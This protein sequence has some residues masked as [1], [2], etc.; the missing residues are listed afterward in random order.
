MSLFA[1][2]DID[3]EPENLSPLSKLNINIF[4]V[5]GST[6]TISTSLA[7][8]HETI[9]VKSKTVIIPK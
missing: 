5:D 2:P 8:A 7:L 1:P 6:V 3:N 4:L 9:I